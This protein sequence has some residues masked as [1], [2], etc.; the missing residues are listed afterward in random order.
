MISSKSGSSGISGASAVVGFKLGTGERVHDGPDVRIIE[1]IGAN[2]L[3]GNFLLIKERRLPV[4][5]DSETCQTFPV[6][7]FSAA[8]RSRDHSEP[9]GRIGLRTSSGGA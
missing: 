1:N 4:S 6:A 9:S 5:S 2:A 8:A 3:L 7:D